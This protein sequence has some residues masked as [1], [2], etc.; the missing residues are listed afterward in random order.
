M[1]TNIDGFMAVGGEGEVHCTF[2]GGRC[3]AHKH[4]HANTYTYT[5]TLTQGVAVVLHFMVVTTIKISIAIKCTM[6]FNI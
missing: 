3:C 1:A 2:Y 6:R 4:A 5:Q